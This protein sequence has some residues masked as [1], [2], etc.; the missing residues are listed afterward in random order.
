MGQTR[1]RASPLTR[2][3]SVECHTRSRAT[4]TSS[5]SCRADLQQVSGYKM[6]LGI[7]KQDGMDGWMDGAETL[8]KKTQTVEV[9]S[10]KGISGERDA[11][12][13]E[14]CGVLWRNE[15]TLV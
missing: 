6:V 4:G 11:W 15:I 3:R 2:E 1:A 13:A 14:R 7:D 9:A 5:T 12:K 10:V 8:N